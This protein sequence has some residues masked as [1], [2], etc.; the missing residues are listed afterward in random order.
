MTANINEYMW[1]PAILESFESAGT[2]FVELRER[3]MQ[4]KSHG[5][6]CAAGAGGLSPSYVQ[7]EPDH[8]QVR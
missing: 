3:E 8:L 1:L 2:A 4:L 7:Q 5:A 6:V